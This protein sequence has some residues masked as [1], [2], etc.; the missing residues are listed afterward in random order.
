MIHGLLGPI[1]YFD[2]QQ[3]CEGIAVHAPDLLGYGEKVEAI[4]SL[5]GPALTLDRQARHV[6]D[7]LRHRVESPAWLLGHSVGGAV[8][9]LAAAQA[10]E[11]V[12][13]VISVEGNFTLDDAFWCR[14]I[15]PL[16]PAEW[17]VRYQAMCSDERAWL[18]AAGIVATPERATW[19]RRI[20]NN[21]P[22]TTVQ[23]MAR[24]V[25]A[26]TGDHKLLNVVHKLIDKGLPIALLSG[27][28]SRR[29]WHVPLWV[30]AAAT[31]EIIMAGAGHMMMLE[32]PE[33]F[34]RAINEIVSATSLPIRS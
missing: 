29:D 24:A 12:L 14:Q 1:D 20:L 26:E 6:A 16:D 28:S 22:A 34:C 32:S 15:A 17:N 13:G 18:R 9:M 10:P 2:P 11:H 4:P 3:Y 25:I 33:P 7:Y 31:Q 27:E 8:A 23:A 30:T 21:Q 5:D 19:A